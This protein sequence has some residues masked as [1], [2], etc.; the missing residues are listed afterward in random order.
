[1]LHKRWTK[2]FIMAIIFSMMLSFMPL[3]I[4]QV[5]GE[6]GRQ[7]AV[8]VQ[9]AVYQAGLFG[10]ETTGLPEF[11]YTAYDTGVLLTWKLP[12]WQEGATNW[13]LLRDGEEIADGQQ[14]T[15]YYEDIGV[16][17]ETTYTYTLEVDNPLDASMESLSHDVMTLAPG[18]GVQSEIITTST[19][20]T[21][22]L[23]NR[24][25]LDMTPDGRTIA[26]SS[27]ADDLAVQDNNEERDIFVMTEDG[28]VERVNLGIGGVEADAESEAPSISDD[29]NLV[30][31]HSY[32]TNLDDHEWTNANQ[33]YLHHR[34]T[35]TT[36]LISRSVE[37]KRGNFNSDS[38]VIS[39]DGST[40]VF[41]SRAT[42]LVEHYPDPTD[43]GIY[44]IY[45][46]DRMNDEMIWITQAHDGQV[47]DASS[48]NPAV[49]EDG[50]FVVFSSQANNLVEGGT[51][52]GTES[53][54]RASHIYVWE[55][56]QGIRMVSQQPDGTFLGDG[57]SEPFIS[58]DGNKVIFYSRA[59]TVGQEQLGL[60][61]NG[62]VVWDRDHD[63][64]ESAVYKANG[65]PLSE[66]L[67]SQFHHLSG[68]GR[69]VSFHSLL[70]QQ[71]TPQD[72]AGSSNDWALYLR[73]LQTGKVWL[74]NLN[75]DGTLNE[76][77]QYPRIN[78]DGTVMIYIGREDGY[79]VMHRVELGA[80]MAPP[81]WGAE[82]ALAAIEIGQTYVNLSWDAAEGTV[83]AYRI[84]RDGN[85]LAEQSAEMYRAEGLSPGTTYTFAV[86]AAGLGLT[87]SQ[88]ELTVSTAEEID[89]EAGLTVI[90][91]AGGKAALVWESPSD[92]ASA[93]GYRIERRIAGDD[94]WHTV[95][96]LSGL[97]TTSFEDN[98]MLANT[99]YEYRILLLFAGQDP[100][101]HTVTRQIQTPNLYVDEAFWNFAE[102]PVV[103]GYAAPGSELHFVVSGE[104]N[105]TVNAVVTYDGWLDSQDQY[106]D[107]QPV[108]RQ[109]EI[110]LIEEEAGSG[111]YRGAFTIP[112]HAAAIR[113]IDAVLTDGAQQL[114]RSF[115]DVSIGILGEL[116]VEVAAG[117]DSL[118]ADGP[119]RL[120][121]WSDEAQFGET[122]QIDAAGTFTFSNL[123]PADDYHV[124]LSQDR[125]LATVDSITVRGGRGHPLDAPIQ[126]EDHGPA[127][128]YVEVVAEQG[129]APLHD[130]PIT[131]KD[132]DTGQILK[133]AVSSLDEAVRVFHS[134]DSVRHENAERIHIEAN[135]KLGQQFLAF[136]Q[137]MDLV[138]GEQ[139]IQLVIPEPDTVPLTG[140]VTDED[141]NPASGIEVTA[142]GYGY[143]STGV[144][145]AAGEYAL[146]VIPG[147]VTV[148][149][150]LR[151]NAVRVDQ[152][153]PI[154][155]TVVAGQPLQDVNLA[156]VQTYRH[157]FFIDSIRYPGE[158]GGEQVLEQVGRSEASR[159]RFT[160]NHEGNP[161][162]GAKR[163][164]AY[165][166]EQ[167]F[168]SSQYNS[169][170]TA[171]IDGDVM[172]LPE[173]CKE[174]ELDPSNPSV[175]VDFEYD[176]SEDMG[177]LRAVFVKPDGIRTVAY[178]RLYD[179]QGQLVAE[180]IAMPTTDY[181]FSLY[182]LEPGEYTLQATGARTGTPYVLE[183]QTVLIPEGE[184][185]DLGTLMLQEL[186]SFGQQ[187]GNTIMVNDPEVT[188]G[189][190]TRF[191]ITYQH[192][193][194]EV[195][196]DAKLHIRLPDDL[197]VEDS[198]ISLNGAAA[199]TTRADN[200]IIIPLGS[201]EPDDQGRI[202]FFANVKQSAHTGKHTVQAVISY[203]ASGDI[204]KELIGSVNLHVGG[205]SMILPDTIHERS[206]IAQGKAPAGSIVRVLVDGHLIEQTVA[207]PNGYW[208]AEVEISGDDEAR[209]LLV[210]AVAIADDQEWRATPA[211]V[212]LDP[213]MPRLTKVSFRQLTDDEYW[214]SSMPNNLRVASGDWTSFQTGSGVVRF[215][216]TMLAGL[217]F[218]FKL[219]FEEPQSVTN[220]RVH[221]EG[222]AGGTAEAMYDE[223]EQVWHAIIETR[224]D[225]PWIAGMIYVDFDHDHTV[226]PSDTRTMLTGEDAQAYIEEPINP[227]EWDWP[228]YAEDHETPD[229]DDN[230]SGPTFNMSSDFIQMRGGITGKLD[231]ELKT[232]E[233]ADSV[234]EQPFQINTAYY[235]SE[236]Y[237]IPE[238]WIWMK[239]SLFQPSK[240][241]LGVRIVGEVPFDAFLEQ[242]VT[243]PYWE[244]DAA[245][246]VES[247]EDSRTTL[248]WHPAYDDLW[249]QRYELEQLDDSGN[250]V[251]TYEVLGDTF[252]LELDDLIAGQS[253]TFRIIAE[254][255]AGLRT[256][257]PELTF[258]AG[259]PGEQASAE[260]QQAQALAVDQ[261][262]E[263]DW[264]K[265][266]RIASVEVKPTRV[267]V[268]TDFM[269][270]GLG[271]VGDMLGT[272]M[273]GTQLEDAV[274]DL[275]ELLEK[276]KDR[277]HGGAPPEL[278]KAVDE[279]ML[280]LA[281]GYTMST[282]FAVGG[283]GLGMTGVGAPG[284]AAFAVVGTISDFGMAAVSGIQQDQAK[285][286][287]KRINL[288]D[289]CE[290]EKDEDDND[291]QPTGGPTGK[292]VAAPSWKIDPSGFI[293]EIVEE[294]RVADVTAT[295][296]YSENGTDPYEVWDGEWWGEE[297]PLSSNA[298]GWYGWDV[299]QGW[300]QV[301]YEKDGYETTYSQH[302]YGPIEVP[303]PHFEVNVPMK[304]YAPPE[305]AHVDA[306]LDGEAVEVSFNRHIRMRTIGEHTAQLWT[307]GDDPQQ[308]EGEWIALDAVSNPY[309]E[310]AED[311]AQTLRFV[312]AEPLV[313]GDEYRLFIRDL[314]E[315]YAEV[316]LLTPH[317]AVIV[318]EEKP[319]EPSNP[320][321]G[322]SGEGDPGDG[323]P[324]EGDSSGGGSTPI[325]PP[326]IPEEETTDEGLLFT[327]ED[328]ELAFDNGNIII[329]PEGVADHIEADTLKMVVEHRD[330]LQQDAPDSF[331]MLNFNLRVQ[332]MEKGQDDA[333][334]QTIKQLPSPMVMEIDLSAYDIVLHD[335]DKTG[336]YFYDEG[337][338]SWQYMMG[339]Y[340]ESTGK[341]IIILDQLGDF[342][343]IQ[344]AVSFTDMVGHWAQRQVEVLAG[345][346]IIKGRSEERFDPDAF[347][348]RAEFTALL[349]RILRMNTN[350]TNSKA[351]QDVEDYHW[352][353]S[354]IAAAAQSKLINGTTEHTFAPFRMIARQEM[355]VI[356]TR[357]LK[358]LGIVADIQSRDVDQ[359]L[360]RFEDRHQLADWAREDMGWLVQKEW[361]KGRSSAMMAPRESLTRAE[362]VMMLS[363]L[364]EAWWE[365]DPVARITK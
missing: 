254:D 193:G 257:G 246:I 126:L 39:G 268:A 216:R 300:W 266:V 88:L 70:G 195:V 255:P 169:T 21:V 45:V 188:H 327:S 348:T 325:Y 190:G 265:T 11:D 156:L 101:E 155:R 98:G 55:R 77:D 121:V 149:A 261:H 137:T 360:E 324:G 146:Q 339:R 48:Y 143:H 365:H 220:V 134:Y 295:L 245:L 142:T 168:S 259:N 296:L 113:S 347:I 241:K 122:L 159:L 333:N 287:Y 344:G 284:A 15:L 53:Y 338:D 291:E 364:L 286:A 125:T 337:S 31:F 85:L 163:E 3:P 276:A 250:A 40:I 359:A 71:I 345:Q 213:D 274:D 141:G 68:D 174:I 355:A 175:G 154:Q 103:T 198:S 285:E 51:N 304:S 138:P 20:Q 41:R 12:L 100:Q 106:V 105:R 277:C 252:Q 282:A 140:K 346:G 221:V 32:A 330:P 316:S 307:T 243:A 204:R 319:E 302:T 182:P 196:E 171:C 69:Y 19:G 132:A 87:T 219:H 197:T 36:E 108:S 308:V 114:D 230:R 133:R 135:P 234:P 212:L 192:H 35:G 272:F 299:P 225:V 289:D 89:G 249:V 81:D 153:E 351:F 18:A 184:I 10:V 203:G 60:S 263:P 164:S 166:M 352:F 8:T 218:E 176:F 23:Y 322:D 86:E 312:P 150:I 233:A 292:P 151:H 9:S 167:Q 90:A 306:A 6:K 331:T 309:K 251:R 317:D 46:Y 210:E 361:I 260:Q 207:A 14:D 145:D 43:K 247:T 82:A 111:I 127:V 264:M 237:E 13:R 5:Q 256:A 273:G 128:I 238:P 61:E 323:D 224:R 217:P 223:Q 248:S 362:A 326:F 118:L 354:E 231:I 281:A 34:N 194:D 199:V 211:E 349:V 179:H 314:V 1:M 301:I 200:S 79:R 328:Q 335:P 341:L 152:S 75:Q 73:D 173:L 215:P 222:P 42:N 84:Y 4:Q 294:N 172:G 214:D 206:L 201:L 242:N 52:G 49:S 17:P 30:A 136:G 185:V 47:P 50:R 44:S 228:D 117:A 227:A 157:F 356:M 283:V 93:Q 104:T 318:V 148:S 270:D 191:R 124:R 165:P 293:Y 271:P 329:R 110:P 235:G 83:D 343:L 187:P 239:A 350:G 26:F 229:S 2:P 321:E 180:K 303:P 96:E 139:T 102:R 57:N 162:I 178:V 120:R 353:A 129:L 94:A 115:G 109:S 275:N 332:L 33:I 181:I 25:K 130:M 160:I 65:S 97:E 208:H 253:Y 358:Q 340:D 334:W 310:T 80:T 240:S 258:T 244:N 183:Q 147:E 186:G 99:L 189:G 288:N 54:D 16:T 123:L 62:L 158:G 116:A 202:H 56:G 363:R 357:A 278:Q 38:P 63:S 290:E 267:K 7:A 66:G 236:D 269:L 313:L 119:A 342:S 161:L 280:A 298:D 58:A 226:I 297:N 72:V 262:Q 336:L 59:S 177:G 112:D 91:E 107:A 27:K 37:D 144:T 64:L 232:T 92:T 28:V 311:V 78:H 315:S 74:V 29:G 305:I 279:A 205:I 24:D 209:W 320:G 170:V 22:K 131:V 67:I 95:Q 76:I